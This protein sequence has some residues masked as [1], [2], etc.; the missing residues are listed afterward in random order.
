MFNWTNP[1]ETLEGSEIPHFTECGPYV[2]LY[3]SIY[4]VIFIFICI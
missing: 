3:V 2:F 4:L 1:Q